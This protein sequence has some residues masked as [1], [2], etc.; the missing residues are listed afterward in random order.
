MGANIDAI[1]TGT[2][3][4]ISMQNTLNYAPTSSGT[5]QLYRSISENMTSYRSS[6]S[7]RASFF[8]QNQGQALVDANGNPIQP[9][10]GTTGNTSGTK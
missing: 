5:H 10:T 4:G 8:D 2:G 3:L 6:D 1:T 9:P 7:S